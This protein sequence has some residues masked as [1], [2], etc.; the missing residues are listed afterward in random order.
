MEKSGGVRPGRGTT[1]PN[2]PP[3]EVLGAVTSDEGVT[4]YSETCWTNWLHDIGG[5]G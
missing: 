4:P 3:T 1:H 2:M 5:A